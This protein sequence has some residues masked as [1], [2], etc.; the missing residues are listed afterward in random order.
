MQK[1][2]TV[3]YRTKA[4]VQGGRQGHVRSEDGVIDLDLAYPGTTPEPAANP[5][6]L[7]A[8]GYAA[9]FQNALLIQARAGG[10]DASASVVTAEVEFGKTDGDDGYGLAVVITA[11]IPG[12]ELAEAQELVEIA[13]GFCPYS[14]ATRGNIEV[15]VT[16][17]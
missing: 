4:S 2:Q 7:F 15:T 12:V 11:Q 5:E 1:I 10:V 13:H 17:V 8:A 16:A 3:T 14:R 9:C 6:T